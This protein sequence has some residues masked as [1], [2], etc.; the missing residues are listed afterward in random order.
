MTTCISSVTVRPETSLASATSTPSGPVNKD[1][2]SWP[3]LHTFSTA[4]TSH[5]PLCSTQ[6]VS[7]LH[8]HL[9]RSISGGSCTIKWSRAACT[10]STVDAHLS[11]KV[12]RYPSR[13]RDKFYLA[14]QHSSD[15]K[16]LA[17]T[18]PAGSVPHRQAS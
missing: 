1:A 8:R 4:D 13:F 15:G 10:A 9:F 11:Q 17:S 7:A 18:V 12:A 6:V 5:S 14:L 16:P 2:R 3:Q